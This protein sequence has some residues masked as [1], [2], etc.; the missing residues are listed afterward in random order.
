MTQRPLILE[1]DPDPFALVDSPWGRIEA[2][3]ASTLACGT[4]GVLAQVAAIVRNDAAEL[5]QKAVELDAKRSAVLS[6]INRLMKFMSRVDALTARV[7]QLEAKRRADE[8][9][10]RELEEEEI[11]LPPDIAEYQTLAP[12]TKIED[13]THHPSGD[14][15]SIDPK[16]EKQPS[17]SELPEPPLETDSDA[18]GVPLSY[19]NV[20]TSY[21]R[22]RGPKDQAGD[23]PKEL[24]QGLPEPVPEPKGSVY[25][26]PIS[27]SL[28]KA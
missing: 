19:G 27:I 7:E 12:A 22:G 9:E 10:Q 24:E 17:S 5:E 8:A 15:H 14:L 23:L 18:G 13:E 11:S 1:N 21:V 3:R 4:M 28:N 2:W 20:P 6:T 25:A 26:Q 16:E